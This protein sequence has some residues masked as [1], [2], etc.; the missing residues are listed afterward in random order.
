MLGVLD[1]E[2]YDCR[3]Q[4][5]T[6]TSGDRLIVYTD[7]VTEARDQEGVALEI[8][9]LNDLVRRCRDQARPAQWPETAARGAGLS[10]GTGH[11]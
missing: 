2:E 6:W 1:G 9:G 10:M 11:G 8:E 5:A 7:G 3:P 4:Q